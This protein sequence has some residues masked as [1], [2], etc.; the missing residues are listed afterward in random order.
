MTPRVNAGGLVTMEIR[1]EVSDA[2]PTTS[3]D[4]DAPTIQQRAIDSVVAVHSGETVMLGGLIRDTASRGGS[5]VPG[6]RR[7]P[8]LGKLFSSSGDTT[9]RTELLV[10]ITPRAVANRGEARAV[11]EEF[12][13]KLK[14]LEP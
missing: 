4:L 3:S 2:V 1:Q 5:G 14:S 7:V 8:L 9:R 13:K 10:L 12:R 11:T 6:L